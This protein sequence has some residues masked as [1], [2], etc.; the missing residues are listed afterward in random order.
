VYK[1]N[2]II[3][4]YVFVLLL[5][6][7]DVSIFFS[8]AHI[9]SYTLLGLYSLSLFNKINVTRLSI[10]ALLLS[11][12]SFLFFGKFGLELIYLIPISIVVIQLRRFVYGNCIY[13][14]LIL[15]L[16]ILLQTFAIEYFLL[17]IKPAIGY[18]N[19]KIIANIIVTWLISL[20]LYTQDNPGNRL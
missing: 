17:G 14:Y 1:T 11:L 8:T 3:L 4:F 20:K 10:I 18:T 6:F 7:V 19:M 16:F 13:P 15:A 12:E 5:F 9:W 2:N